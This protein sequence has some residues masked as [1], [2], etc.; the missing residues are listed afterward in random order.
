MERQAET[1]T[2]TVTREREKNRKRRI[3]VPTRAQTHVVSEYKQL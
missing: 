3:G 2:S 1:Q